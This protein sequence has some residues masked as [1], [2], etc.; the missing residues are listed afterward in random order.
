MSWGTEIR[1]VP[2]RKI[3]AGHWEVRCADGTANMYLGLASI[4]GAGLLGVHDS[5]EL[6]M[7]DVQQSLGK[8]TAAERREMGITEKLPLS[9]KE[10]LYCLH[11]DDLMAESLG[12]RLVEKYSYHKALEESIQTTISEKDRRDTCLQYW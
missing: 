7:K 9:L 3:K 11:Q 1:D 5:L 12:M 2:I 8:T 4:L 10:A 6:T